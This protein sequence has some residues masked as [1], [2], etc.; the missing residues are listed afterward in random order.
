MTRA[1]LLL[2]CV[3][4]CVGVA[5][6]SPTYNLRDLMDEYIEEMQIRELKKRDYCVGNPC[7]SGQYCYSGAFITGLKTTFCSKSSDPCDNIVSACGNQAAQCTN[8]GGGHYICN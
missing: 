2:I 5:L 3:A 4:L 7:P 8:Y 6:T 1:S